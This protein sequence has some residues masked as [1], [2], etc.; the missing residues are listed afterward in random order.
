MRPCSA[1]SPA[2]SSPPGALVAGA[3]MAVGA[4][5]A[6]SVAGGGGV[7][8]PDVGQR[9]TVGT[10]TFGGTCSRCSRACSTPDI[11]PGRTHPWRAASRCL[12]CFW[13]ACS[14]PAFLRLPRCRRANEFVPADWTG[15]FALALCS[16]VT[17]QGLLVYA[18]WPCPPLV[19]GIVILT[20]PALSALLRLDLLWRGLHPARLDGGGDDRRGAGPGPAEEAQP[21]QREPVAAPN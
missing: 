2:S 17:G 4:A 8:P 21:H 1:M 9:R 10:R 11:D 19:V 7:R 13:P 5:G 20:Q 6:G 14:G 15:L 12:C 16:Q 18:L 3:Q